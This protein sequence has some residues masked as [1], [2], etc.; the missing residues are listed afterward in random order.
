[1]LLKGAAD[2][3]AAGTP[4]L[5]ISSQVH[6]SET[7]SQDITSEWL[8]GTET[9]P[10][11]VLACIHYG[12]PL[13]ATQPA[14]ELESLYRHHGWAERRLIVWEAMQRIHVSQRKL[15]QFAECGSALWLQ[16]SAAGDDLRLVCN[17]CKSRWCEPCMEK[18]SRVIREN[19]AV[20]LTGKT[21]RFVTLTLRHSN[22]RLTDQIDRL[23]RSFLE[24]RR[25]TFWKGN[26]EGGAA[27]LEVKVSERD[28]MWHPHL[29][30]IVQGQ[31]MDARELSREWHS[32]TGDSSIVDIRSVDDADKVAGYVTKYVTKPA[33]LSVFKDLDK[34]DEMMVSLRGRRL[35]TTFGTWR[36]VKLEHVPKGTVVWKPIGSLP[37]LLRDARGGDT[38]ARAHCEAA[39]RKFPRLPWPPW[40]QPDARPKPDG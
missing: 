26:V 17:C 39:A 15:E 22:T 25:R 18:R 9:V 38:I 14:S 2:P 37:C 31:W 30:V 32:V 20:L 1:M 36:G 35:L 27:F 34:L 24:L 28:G 6:P 21:V 13:Y 19:M 7:K 4:A 10:G 11:V 5:L 3:T 23:Y 16:A 12:D 8:C 29:H 33:H 40:L